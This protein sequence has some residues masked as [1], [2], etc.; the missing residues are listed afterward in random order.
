VI[1]AVTK[2]GTN[3]FHGTAFDFLRN[4]KLDAANFFTNSQGLSKN[5]LRQNQFGAAGGWR[6]LKDRL[7][8]F[9]DYEGVRKS[10]GLPV[11]NN[12][13]ISDNARAGK[14]VNLATGATV[15]VASINSDILKFLPLFPSPAS[16]TTG[17]VALKST[18]FS[19]PGVAGGCNPNIGNAPFLGHQG[20]VEDFVTGRADYRL[21]ANDTLFGTFLRDVSNF[22]TPNAF[23]ITQQAFTSYREAAILEETHVFSATWT[24]TVRGALDRTN[25]LGGNSP[26]ANNPAAGNTALGMNS[27][28]LSG[29][30]SPGITL[31]GVGTTPGLPGGQ[32]YSDSIQDFWGQIAQVYD[33]AFHSSGNHSF[34]LGFSF[35][36]QQVDGYVPL[37]GGNG[38]GTFNGTGV[39]GGPGT[40]APSHTLAQAPCGND[41]SCGALVNFL[42]DQPL[43]ASR[44]I[45]LSAIHKHY[46]RDKIF[47]VYFQD[48]YRVRPNLTLNLGLRY[49]MSTIP[50]EK[51]GKVAIIPTPS[52]VLPCAPPTSPTDQSCSTTDPTTALSNVFFT[53][54]PTLKNFEPRIG[55][56]WDPFKSGKTSIRGGYG[57]FDSLPLAYQLILNNNSSA[58]WRGTFATLGNGGGGLLASPPQGAWPFGIPAL[59]NIHVN[60]PVSRN[61]MYIEQAPKRNYVE[62][63]SLNIQRQLTPSLSI[64]VGYSGTRAFHN[65]FQAD[66]VNTILPVQGGPGVGYYWPAFHLVAGVPVSDYT[67]SQ[68]PAV[69]TS[70]LINPTAGTTMYNTMW[71][72]RSWYNGLQV[73]VDK[74]LSNGFQIQGSYTYSKSMDDSSGS[75][76]GDTFQLDSVSEPWYDL[77]L[78]KGLSDFDVRHNLVINALWNVPSP[79]KLGVIGDKV[80]G[81]WQLGVIFTVASG[82][83]ETVILG[84]DIGGELAQTV[85]PPN[86]VAGCNPV[87]ANYRHSLSYI[88]SSCFTLVPKTTANTPFCDTFRTG[89]FSTP[90][91]FCPNIRGNSGRDTIIGPGL[92]NTNFSA[93]KNNYVRKISESFNV[94][95]RAEMFNVFNRTNFAPSSVL[96]TI[97][98]VQGTANGNFGLLQSTQTDNR[99][100]QLALKMIW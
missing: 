12:V 91:G 94:Q 55:F 9:G 14:I 81:G 92:V 28:G 20:A 16:G 38:S 82:I 84:Q 65:P 69:Q 33:D 5:T 6:I 72:S 87:N 78:S 63:F 26:I 15:T 67:G 43:S 8:L 61:W 98:D 11:S 75:T 2:S 27:S 41:A 53:K 7:F 88:N 68:A 42:T 57:I 29:F 76:A 46:L 24:N 47:G 85:Q 23:N 21:G 83:P 37:A 50:T 49:E 56:A 96:N 89:S 45:D 34:K 25:N 74:R 1:N 52:T 18:Q 10:A 77:S 58:P 3:S 44:P 22:N 80:I 60:N 100:I 97:S 35:F 40:G 59:V 99:V 19:A 4:D 39:Y 51:Y 90:A 30:T 17:C 73:K 64:L 93:F 32:N 79:K 13:S 66:T 95:F 71:Q 36:A 31:T 48:D 70:R 86:F 62:Q 54:N